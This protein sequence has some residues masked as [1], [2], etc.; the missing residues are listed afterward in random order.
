MNTP[1]NTPQSPK[2]PSAMPQANTGGRQIIL[3]ISVAVA[4]LFVIGYVVIYGNT[5]KSK[6]TS[7]A[8][9][10]LPAAASAT[11]SDTGFSPQSISIK[12][13]TELT[14]TNN[15]SQA[16]QVSAD[17]YPANNSITGFDNNQLLEKGDSYSFTFQKTGTYHVHDNLN[18]LKFNQ[19]II[20]K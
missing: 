11:I 19:T 17:P 14:W 1:T 8:K 6:S 7:S 15:D 5:N 18:P 2:E 20:V 3:L 10:V 4:L 12:P 16:H 9:A 13:N